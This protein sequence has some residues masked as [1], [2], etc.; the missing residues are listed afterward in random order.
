MHSLAQVHSLAE[1]HSLV[2]ANSLAHVFPSL[3]SARDSLSL[4]GS[5]LCDIERY[6]QVDCRTSTDW[7]AE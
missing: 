7:T 5:V 6:V 3:L 2:H 4:G 1:V